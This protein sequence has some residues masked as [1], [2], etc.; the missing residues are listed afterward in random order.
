M[1][2]AVLERETDSA[3]TTAARR[4]AVAQFPPRDQKASW[5]ATRRTRAE[6]FALLKAAPF[7]A[8]NIGSESSRGLG[9]RLLL[10]WLEDQPGSTWQDRWLAS[11]ADAAGATWRH[12]SARWLHGHGDDLPSRHASLSE[13]LPSVIS[14]DIVRPSLGWLLPGSAGHRSLV[15]HLGASR[16]R[17]GFDRLRALTADESAISCAASNQ[18]LYRGALII[19]T[20]GGLLTDITVGDVLELFDAEDRKP[21]SRTA[22]GR[23][24][25]YR[26]MRELGGAFADLARH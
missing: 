8:A 24:L 7:T 11:G 14:A 12:V 16:D 26:S 25:F 5:P 18:T 1:T 9:S 6:A 22:S 23:A 19:S 21:S 4:A 13:A 2:V 17:D 15:R 10:D 3:T 20:K